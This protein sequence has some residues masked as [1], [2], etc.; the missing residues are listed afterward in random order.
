MYGNGVAI[1]YITRWLEQGVTPRKESTLVVIGPSSCGK[2]TAVKAIIDKLT[3]YD[4]HHIQNEKCAGSC[5]SRDLIDT[6]TKATRC[7][8]LEALEGR[9]PRKKLII[10]DEL[11][12]YINIDRTVM[13]ILTEFIT[14]TEKTVARQALFVIICNKAF[15]RR[16]SD[17]RNVAST[18]II[19][20]ETPAITDIYKLLDHTYPGACPDMLLDIARSANGY[21]SQAL[22][23]ASVSVQQ[24]KSLANKSGL[25]SCDINVDNNVNNNVNNNVDINNDIDM[26]NLKINTE[27][28][29]T[30]LT[31]LEGLYGPNVPSREMAWNV[32]M[33]DPWM[34]PLRFHENIPREL[35]SRKGL[36]CEKETVYI[37]TL[38]ALVDWDFIV[39]NGSS[40]DESSASYSLP[41]A[42]DVMCGIPCTVLPSLK[43]GKNA[44]PQDLQQFTKMLS[45]LSLQKKHSRTMQKLLTENYCS[46]P[47]KSAAFVITEAATKKTSKK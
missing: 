15:E 27:T 43:R 26:S 13:G 11:E 14:K 28:P 42:I 23:N 7:N 6:L 18:N 22:T 10:I 36:K 35:A 4:V 20:F 19:H 31:D 37:K 25:D 30:I 21:F 5:N 44:D 38:R 33:I 45:R 41:F 8:L 47:W 3:Q 16:L 9:T 24:H 39:G 32:L 12:L 17:L 1:E 40:S 34:Y 29:D 2:T 46:L